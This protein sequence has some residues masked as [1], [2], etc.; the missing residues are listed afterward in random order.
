MD[1]RTFIGT[2][3]GSLLVAPL[4][5]EAQHAGKVYRIG[6]LLL[7]P[8][9]VQLHLIEAFEAGLREKGYPLGREVVIEYRSADGHSDQLPILAAELVRLDVDVIVTGV[10]P[11]T[12][13]AKHATG[14]T[15]IVMA[16]SFFPV[17][18]GLVAS[19]ARPGGNVTGLT[20]EAGEEV[21][22]RLQLLREEVP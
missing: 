5:A 13:A 15:P 22:K 11:N 19:L 10:N 18:D 16:S 14:T 6:F 17:E 9:D 21:A 7:S 12:L 1:R 3:T 20:Q 8:R 2:L 4:A